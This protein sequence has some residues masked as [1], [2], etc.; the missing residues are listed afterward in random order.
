[1]SDADPS[2]AWPLTAWQE[3]LILFGLPFI[4]FAGAYGFGLIGYDDATYYRNNNLLCGGE[5]RGLYELWTGP[6]YSDY[7]PVTQLT[8]WFDMRLGGPEPF[9][10]SRIHGLIWIGIGTLGLHA[11]VARATGRREIGFLV[12]LLFAVH[13][14]SAPTALWLAERKNQLCMAFSFWSFERYVAA[15]TAS[16]GARALKLGAAAYVLFA[17]ALLSK[18]HGLALP[19]MLVAYELTLGPGDWK[20][21]ARWAAPFLA[22]AAAFFLVSVT[23]IRKDLSGEYL[24]GSRAAAIASDGPILLAYLGHTVAPVRLSFF[25]EVPELQPSDP[26]AWGAWALFLGAMAAC[27]GIAG[28]E[29]R[30]WV[31]FGWLWGLAAMAPAINIAPQS[32]PMM[33]HYNHWAIPGWLL[34]LV[35]TAEGALARLGSKAA[36]SRALAG[37]A[38]V[39]F[40][41][42][43]YQRVEEFSSGLTL[44]GNAVVRQ[45][46]SGLAWTQYALELW[47]RPE[48]EHKA[49]VGGA[50]LRALSLPDSARIMPAARSTLMVEAAIALERAGRPEEARAL[51]ERESARLGPGWEGVGNLARAKIAARTGKPRDAVAALSPVFAGALVEA[52]G[53]LRASCRKGPKLPFELQP[54][55]VLKLSG[56][57][58]YDRSFSGRMKLESLHVLAE[59]NLKAGDLE[60]AFDVAAV[61]A[62]LAPDFP[63][64]R[65]VLADAYKALGEP[66]LAERCVAGL[67][68]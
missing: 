48:P 50:A 67:K 57:D 26:W 42:F 55:V 5:W 62:N 51:V 58:G 46:E 10:I 21:R 14:L 65:A 25:Y 34:A 11:L 37:L 9:L 17:L 27:V 36:L 13:P 30:A 12:A 38:A 4:L 35:F 3:R 43:S 63:P 29:R 54:L 18:I 1:M 31:L 59:A 23:F 6:F 47:T 53:P 60:A 49:L 20:R 2:T 33:D 15:R 16:D 8:W 61:L 66:A 24:G 56:G 52:V 7:F 64:A 28:R 32:L 22:S 40:A 68:R 44:F 45:P 41:V 39:F 19:P